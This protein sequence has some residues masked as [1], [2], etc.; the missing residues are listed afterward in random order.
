MFV[1]FSEAKRTIFKDFF[2]QGRNGF[3]WLK[4][5]KEVDSIAKSSKH[6]MREK[7]NRQSLP[8]I[9]CFGEIEFFKLLGCFVR[10]FYARST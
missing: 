1:Y 6:S 10:T 5:V 8:E 4:M 2:R 7:E 9:F 3:K